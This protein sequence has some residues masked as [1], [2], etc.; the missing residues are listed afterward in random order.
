LSNSLPSEM[1]DHY[2][3]IDE[4]KRLS[5]GAGELEQIRTKELIERASPKNR[6][7][8]VDVGGAAGVYSLWL[9][10][11][12]HEVHLIDP[13]PDHVARAQAASEGQAMHRLSGCEVGDAR[14]L[15]RPDASA[16]VVLMLGP[17][18]HLTERGDRLRAL[19]EAHALCGQRA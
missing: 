11:Q 8:I 17:L 1:F 13:V 4:S 19:R 2:R 16:D 10:R 15:R 18:Y 9:A 12:G 14:D 5:S 7:V 6:S 3:Q